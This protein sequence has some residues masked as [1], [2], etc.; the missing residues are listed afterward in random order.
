MS[1]VR[2]DS[3]QGI[4]RPIALFAGQKKIVQIVFAYSGYF[5]LERMFEDKC[6]DV[7]EYC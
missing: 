1:L 3:N 7:M 6:S 5:I 4:S 2:I